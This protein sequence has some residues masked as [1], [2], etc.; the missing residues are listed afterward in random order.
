M[1]QA[2]HGG[3]LYQKLIF[4]IDKAWS[5][6]TFISIQ[7]KYWNSKPVNQRDFEVPPHDLNITVLCAI[8]AALIVGPIFKQY[9]L[10]AHFKHIL[11]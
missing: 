6:L 7:N 10:A 3:I 1:L 4:F 9:I 2:V 5:I 8:T 11:L